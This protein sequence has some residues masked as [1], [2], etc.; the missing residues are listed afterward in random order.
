MM[1]ANTVT[2]I[3]P[4][5]FVGVFLDRGNGKWT[6]GELRQWR[7]GAEKTA[8]AFIKELFEAPKPAEIPAD[9]WNEL[10]LL[11]KLKFVDDTRK[12]C[13]CG[14]AVGEGTIRRDVEIRAATGEVL[15]DETYLR[16]SVVGAARGS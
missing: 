4:C 12:G 10:A 6:H 8:A 13:P 7:R 2:R 15:K 9:Q 16:S 3:C 1:A 11:K 5:G 14:L